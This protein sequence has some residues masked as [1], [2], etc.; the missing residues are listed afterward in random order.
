MWG[1]E[2]IDPDKRDEF[3]QRDLLVKLESL[4]MFMIKGSLAN[5]HYTKYLKTLEELKDAGLWA[6]DLDV[7]NTNLNQKKQ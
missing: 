5:S 3:A 7:G 2:E 6:N 1:S 4:I